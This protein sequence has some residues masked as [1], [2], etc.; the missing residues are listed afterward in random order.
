MRDPKRLTR[1]HRSVFARILVT[2]VVMALAILIMVATFFGAMIGR[3]L[4]A[5]LEAVSREY[6]ETL[7]ASSPDLQK[8]A[9]IAERLDMDVS[10]RG[11]AGTWSTAAL[12]PE[13]PEVRPG[14]SVVRKIASVGVQQYIV[15]QPDGGIY[16]F[17]MR[18]QHR[19]YVA[20]NWM[21]AGLLVLV[22][23]AVITAYALLRREL[24]P[25]R[26]LY[27]GVS[28]LREGNLEVAVPR[29]TEDE[30][31]ALTDAFNEMVVRVRDMVK[32]R[33]QLLL[34]VSHELRSPLTRMK[35]ALELCEDGE[36]KQRMAGNV[37]E[38]ELMVTELLE[39]ERLRDSRGIKLERCDLMPVVRDVVRAF[40]GRAPGVT[41]SA[42]PSE[43]MLDLDR[44]WTRRVLSNV[45]ENA[46]KY[47]LPDSR[48]V[49]VSV[50]KGAGSVVVR[51]ADDGPGIPVSDLP[52]L[53]E[54]FFRVDRSRS[55]KT[56]GYGLGL[57][58]CKRIMEAHG[59]A[60]EVRNDADR[61]ASFLLTF[62]VR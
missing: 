4:T 40:E 50:S 8:A 49:D 42:A 28:G 29:R 47:C 12:S 1:P 43:A 33:D 55:R 30:F 23:A 61:G 11:P 51:V 41:V 59:G 10:Y 58:L 62:P 53:F 46:F 7:A 36:Q 20:H 34:D 31:G 5:S 48:A 22:A 3:T 39:L 32:S 27:D 54:P 37:R 16:L 44:E 52:H 60:I 18:Y 2:M 15:T 14:V 35:V 57:S 56:G 19:L 13:F 17:S 25:L 24:R 38:M 21:L 26:W 6:V 9:P 45:L